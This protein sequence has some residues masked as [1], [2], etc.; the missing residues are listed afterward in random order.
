MIRTFIQS[1]QFSKAW[2]E[3]IYDDDELRKIEI[4]IM[5]NPKKYPV[6]KGTG[7]LRKLRWKLGNKGKR[8]GIRIC[9]VDFEEHE[10]VYMMLLYVKNEKEDLTKEEVR[11]VKT[12]RAEVKTSFKQKNGEK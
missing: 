6:I 5:Q 2:D 1:P 11:K 4:D 10:I 8:G 7:G 9:Y 12:Y 3:Y